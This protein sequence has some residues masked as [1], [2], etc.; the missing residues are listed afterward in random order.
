MI[1]QLI[2]GELIKYFIMVMVFTRTKNIVK[3][4]VNFL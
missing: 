3:V 4:L 2:N 1:Y